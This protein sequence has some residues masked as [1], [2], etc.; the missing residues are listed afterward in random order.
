MDQRLDLVL[1]ECK[2][3][4]VGVAAGV[5]TLL[6]LMFSIR[7][8]DVVIRCHSSSGAKCDQWSRSATDSSQT[9]RNA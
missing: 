1:R 8:V 4:E 7:A 5:G 6:T 3:E 9:T 2:L